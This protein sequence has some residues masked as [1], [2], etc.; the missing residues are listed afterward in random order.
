MWD[1]TQAI[2]ITK[3]Q[4]PDLIFLDLVMPPPD[5]KAVLKTLKME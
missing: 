1:G 3:Q 5:G 2:E 4:K